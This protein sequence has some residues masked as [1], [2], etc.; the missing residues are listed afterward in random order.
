MSIV[1]VERFEEGWIATGLAPLREALCFDSVD[2]MPE[3]LRSRVAVLLTTP[4]KFY[5]DTIGRRVTEDIF[6]V[7]IGADD[8]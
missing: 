7:H 8:G 6:W 4:P 5:N 3:P 1:R 2:D